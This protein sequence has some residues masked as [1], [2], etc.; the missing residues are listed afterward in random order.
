MQ[1]GPDDPVAVG[2]V[3]LLALGLER[4]DVVEHLALGLPYLIFHYC[5][6]LIYSLTY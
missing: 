4:V 2:L 6:L 1:V 3:V 5:L